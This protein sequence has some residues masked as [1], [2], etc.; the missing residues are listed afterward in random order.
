[1]QRVSQRCQTW[2]I[3]SGPW[4]QKS[5]GME[6]ALFISRVWIG[7]T[8]LSTPSSRIAIE[9][10]TFLVAGAITSGD[11]EIR[12]CRADHLSAVIEKLEETGVTIERT[13]PSILKVSAPHGIKSRDV[14]TLE[15]P[16]FATDM[17]AQYMALMTQGEGTVDCHRNHF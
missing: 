11:V 8:V 4:V 14:T 9:T 10:G 13:P 12:S 1:M 15:H 17:Q 7:C 6:A 3:C 2:L 5:A 16:G